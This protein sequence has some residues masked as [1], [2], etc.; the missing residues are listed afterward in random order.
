MARQSTADSGKRNRLGFVWVSRLNRNSCRDALAAGE[1]IAKARLQ[2]PIYS[3]PIP[4]VNRSRI[5][6]VEMRVQDH[7]EHGAFHAAP[8]C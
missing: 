8:A 4:W 2:S 1:G 5:A 6:R 7:A 3:G